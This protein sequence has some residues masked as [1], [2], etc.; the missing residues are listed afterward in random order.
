MQHDAAINPL[1][2]WRPDRDKVRHNRRFTHAPPILRT[3]RLRVEHH[4]GGVVGG[5]GRQVVVNL[6][7]H[8]DPLL[9]YERDCLQPSRTGRS[10]QDYNIAVQVRHPIQLEN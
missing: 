2:L 7:H 9:L 10:L 5:D 8:C 6:D 3:V 1:K 4:I